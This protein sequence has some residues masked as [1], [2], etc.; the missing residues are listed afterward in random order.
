MKLI[1]QA[2]LAFQGGSSDKIY[3]VDLCEVGDDQY[4]VNFRYGRRGAALREGSKTP[5]PVPKQKAEQ[6]YNKLIADKLKKGYFDTEGGVQPTAEKQ[7]AEPVI[8]PESLPQ[9][10]D[11]RE[12]AILARLV[13]GDSREAPVETAVS[14][15]APVSLWQQVKST[16]AGSS[17]KTSAK[18]AKNR[19]WPLDR[20]IWR[21]GELKLRAAEPFLLHL[22]SP[23]DHERNYCIIH[24][25]G[26]CGSEQAIPHLQRLYNT[27]GLPD[28]L[29]R[30]S[31]EALLQLLPVAEQQQLCDSLLDNL[32]SALAEAARHG[33]AE[34]LG[35]ALDDYFADVKANAH[36]ALSALYQIDNEHTRPALLQRLRQLPLR[37]PY[38]KG[39]R[40]IFKLAEYRN[41]A[42]VFG[43]LAY[44]FETT[45][46]MFR[47]DY[48]CA[49][50]QLESGKK[51]YFDAEELKREL[52]SPKAKIAYGEKTRDYLRRRVW[53]SLRRL[54]E[55][56]SPKYAEMAAGVLLA[57]SDA[58]A[59]PERVSSYYDYDQGREHLARWTNYAPYWAFNHI[60]YGHSPRYCAAARAWKYRDG[61]KPEEAPPKTREE[62]FPELWQQA[63]ETLLPLLTRG[64]CL[65]VHEFAVKALRACKEFCATLD[66]LRL[67]IQLL[68]CEY[69]ITA[70]FGFELAEQQYD[71]ARPNLDL[72]RAVITCAYAPA[73]QQAQAWIQARREP[74]LQDK[75]FLYDIIIAL[76]ADT[77]AFARQLLRGASLPDDQARVLIDRLAAFF[78]D[79][80]ESQS[81]Q[82][83]DIAETVFKGFGPQLRLLGLSIV[84]DLLQHPL[85]C[86]QELAADILLNYHDCETL[87]ESVFFQLLESPH[88]SIRGI[89]MRLLGQ[90]SD[91][92][93][94]KQTELLAVLAANSHADVR[95][96]VLPLIAR[97]HQTHPESG[98][99]L[100]ELL[101]SRLLKRKLPEGAPA[102]LL[103]L[104]QTELQ[105]CLPA[106]PQDSVLRLLRARNQ[107]AQELGGRLLPGN[108]RV[109]DLSIRQIITLAEHEI[110]A[111]RQAAW[112]MYEQSLP[113]VKQEMAIAIK[114]LDS[115]WN[116]TREFSFDFFS[117]GYFSQEEFT[118]EVLTGVC[119]SVREDAQQ[120]GRRLISQYFTE[121][122]GQEYML[123]LSEHPSADMQ[124]F[125]T[126]YLERYASDS[127]ERLQHL[128]PYLLSALSRVNKG[129]IAKQRIYR[130]LEEE[131]LKSASA[132]RIVAK[133]LTRQSA[134]MAIGGKAAAIRAM[135]RIRQVYPEIELPVRQV[136]VEVR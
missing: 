126:N 35:N 71:P 49:W 41:D 131:A 120:F 129:R 43:M 117:Q 89:G 13:R 42:E 90:L 114:I 69:E 25:L 64:R 132:A 1:K 128:T 83:A 97:L 22:L 72:A 121:A 104:L 48:G 82:A 108:V 38:F 32:P 122:D 100:A 5:L 111:I 125:V 66:E 119:D 63:P 45:G 31:M 84:R 98:R 53:R 11:P 27:A 118:P 50:V 74:F 62:A 61:R 106:I 127:P 102:H 116:D 110:L 10:A 76:H 101:V 14:P 7:D 77:R 23:N 55:L 135:V 44:R 60:L 107:W 92:R 33:P 96:A 24:A 51:H 103:H 56:Q 26:H 36:A 17:K 134:G 99:D 81:E 4:V 20:A 95:N 91:K 40:H 2:N 8:L 113:R 19:S 75:A 88:E 70:R 112:H 54:G 133:I 18:P 12:Q 67:I 37:P 85:Q 80:D 59:M 115:R 58:D 105:A 57:F 46:A 109:E 29:R 34:I 39:L 130:F 9:T 6:I 68:N 52:R 16:I 30:L 3:E 124:L 86:V 15:D 93:L 28:M 79:L 87:P 65:V 123:K 94:L 73:R 136:G 78:H 21:A 47:T